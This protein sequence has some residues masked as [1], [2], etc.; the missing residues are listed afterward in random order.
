MA[1]NIPTS[2][3]IV[4]EI[5]RI[6]NKIDIQP[7]PT[8]EELKHGLIMQIVILICLFIIQIIC[9]YI[10]GKMPLFIF[11]TNLISD[12][13]AIAAF[14]YYIEIIYDLGIALFNLISYK[15]K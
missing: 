6:K 15:T 10:S 13:F 8:F 14:L 3:L 2:T 4:S 11:Y 7:E 5:N 1:I 12:A 9:N